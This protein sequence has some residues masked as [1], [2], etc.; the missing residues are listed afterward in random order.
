MWVLRK[1]SKSSSS[2]RSGPELRDSLRLRAPSDLLRVVK[3]TVETGKTG[4]SWLPELLLGSL[5]RFSGRAGLISFCTILVIFSGIPE[6]SRSLK[7]GPP[8]IS[9]TLSPLKYHPG[10]ERQKYF[11]IRS[12]SDE[13]NNF[14]R[15]L[16]NPSSGP[17]I[18][19]LRKQSG[20]SI[21]PSVITP[22][23]FWGSRCYNHFFRV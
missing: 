17:K 15:P 5:A 13:S 18:R 1:L 20:V 8:T 22:C 11:S 23:H 4:S 7:V 3:F 12:H 14:V 10:D 2:E 16:I 9:R 6:N 21:I 19:S